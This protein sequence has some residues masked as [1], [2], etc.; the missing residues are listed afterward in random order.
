MITLTNIKETPNDYGG[1]ELKK[2]IYMDGVR[3]MVKFPDPA[4]KK[5]AVE[6]YINN[7]FS[8]E[9]GSKIF[10]YLGIPTQETFLAKYYV[11][12]KEK[13][14]VVCKD[15]RPEGS[16]L[17]EA[18]TMGL[19]NVESGKKMTHSIEDVE[20]FIT[21][22]KTDEANKQKFLQQFWEIFL[23]DTLLGNVDRHLGNWGFLIDRDDNYEFAPVYD[24]GSTL[25]PLDSDKELAE[26]LQDET[27][28][29][30]RAY[31]LYPVYTLNNQKIPYHEFYRRNIE[32]LGKAVVKLVP[33]MNMDEIDR[34]IDNTEAMSDVRKEFMKKSIRMRYEMILLP[35]WQKKVKRL[36][37]VTV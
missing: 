15:F 7:V 29:K 30:N 36:Q 13:I 31:N 17:I 21:S 28:L 5:D 6:K 16:R 37:I 10:A 4:R 2:A 20:Y 12:E 14:V 1:S 11:G 27:E 26:L 32:E 23:V 9:V 34:I 22:L 3:Y 19:S 18:G 8:E 33:R 25:A 24:C 35:A